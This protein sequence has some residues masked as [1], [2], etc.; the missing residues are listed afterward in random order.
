MSLH[1]K[2][3]V[4]IG[5]GI[6]GLAL[7]ALMA[8]EG[9]KVTLIEKN[10]QPGGRATVHKDKGF[11][12]DMGPSWYLMPDIFERFYAEF[13]LKPT[14]LFELKKLNTHYRIFYSKDDLIDIKPTPEAN[15]ELFE[16]IEPGSYAKFLELLKLSERNYKIAIDRFVY[17]NY[18]KLTDFFKLDIAMEG[19]KINALGRFDKFINKYFKSKRLQ[20][21]MQYTVVFLGSSPKQ[22]PAL[23]SIMTHVDFNLGVWYPMGGMAQIPKS[24]M[25]IGQNLGVKYI[26]DAPA[27]KIVVEDGVAKGVEY[28]GKFLEADLVIS[29]ADYPFT[30]MKLLEKTYRTY[31]EKYWAKRT[32]APSAFIIYLGVK[33]T[34]EKLKHHNLFFADDWETHFDEIF[35]KPRWPDDPS[36]YICAPSKSDPSVAP[37]EHENLFILVP[38]AAGIE[39]NDQIRSEYREKILG[40]IEELTSFDIRSNIVCERIFS[41]NDYQS[42]YNSYKGNA[43]GLAHSLRQSA[44]FR[45]KNKSKKVSNLY[46]VGQYTIPGVGVPMAIISAQV[47]RDRILEDNE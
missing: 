8:K 39:D 29:N 42:Y 5:A 21:I 2:N 20:K 31:D 37:K 30:E 26:F 25:K 11:T 10:S 44:V 41:I 28:N 38:I 22:T 23:Y 4:I 33:G 14:D 24:I 36:Y 15:R 43:L 45:P 13:G 40:H 16:S 32:I 1:N 35:E 27:S 47:V 9:A 3:V 19:A 17:K 34:I 18:N 46:Y 7:S 12:F 6:G